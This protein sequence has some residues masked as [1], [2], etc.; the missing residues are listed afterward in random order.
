[1]SYRYRVIAD[2]P[3]GYWDLSNANSGSNYDITSASNHAFISNNV[4]FSTP[5]IILN[6]ASSAKISATTASIRINNTYDIF[7]LNAQNKTFAIEFW[8]SFNNIGSG[9]GYTVNNTASSYY[10]NNQLD[11]LKTINRNSG[12]TI[13]R[14]FYDYNSNT[15]RF[16]FPGSN[17][18]D[19]YTYIKNFDNP[20]YIVAIYQ[21]GKTNIILNGIPGS[22]SFVYDKTL[23]QSASTASAVQFVID[24]SSLNS[25]YSGSSSFLVSNLA[26]YN[27]Q[28]NANVIKNHM[29]WANYQDSPNYYS[30]INQSIDYFDL[31]NTE[32]DYALYK[33]PD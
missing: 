7:N 31:I 13:S 20:I 32:N 12:S 2:N 5:P 17:N 11:I 29:M 14:I 18:N 15:I 9:N 16:S 23:I 21:G 3:L 6:S 10:N 27:Y 4:V 25:N 19:A 28:L 33:Q 22:E 26:F 8:L 24:G 1:M 30:N